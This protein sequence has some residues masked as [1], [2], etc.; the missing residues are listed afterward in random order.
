MLF[1]FQS[2]RTLDVTPFANAKSTVF[3]RVFGDPRSASIETIIGW[4]KIDYSGA[5]TS[6]FTPNGLHNLTNF[7]GAN[8]AVNHGYN[9][10]LKLTHQSLL[11]ILNTLPTVTASRT[12]TLG[13]TNILKLTDE[14]IAIATAKGWTVA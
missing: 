7:D 2:M 3:D 9:E 8:I 13:P 14:E 10:C 5:P 12:I 4:S 1:S 11:N 6:G